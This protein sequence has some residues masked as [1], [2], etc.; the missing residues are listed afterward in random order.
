MKLIRLLLR[1]SRPAFFAALI[2]SVISGL[3]STF[4]I[5][6]ISRALQSANLLTPAFF[7]RFLTLILLVIGTDLFSKLVLN[8]LTEAAYRDMQISLAR[9]ILAAPIERLEAAGAPRLMVALTQ[10]VG[11]VT[12]FLQ[13][14]PTVSFHVAVAV[15]A[16]A[17]LFWVSFSTAMLMSVVMAAGVAGY[18]VLNGRARTHM[19]QARKI[20]DRIFHHYEG[21][22]LGAKELKLHGRRRLRFFERL[23]VPETQT[24]MD[25]RLTGRNQHEIANTWTNVMYFAFVLILFILVGIQGRVDPAILTSFTLVTLYLRSSIAHI[26]N[27]VPSYTY[28]TVALDAIEALQ[29]PPV[30]PAEVAGPATAAAP[31]STLAPDPTLDGSPPWE[32]VSLRDVTFAY[33]DEE[34]QRTFTLGPLNLTFHPGELVFLIGGNGSGKTTLIKLLT[35]LYTPDE[36]EILWDGATVTAETVEPY[37]QNFTAIFSDFYLFEDLLGFESPAHEEQARFY[38]ERLRLS[39]KVTISDGHLSTTKL[40]QGQRK[41]L[42]LLT[43]YLEDRPIYV[44]DE[45]AAGQDPQFTDIFYR[46]MLPELKE[47][48]KLVVVVSH[49]DHYFDVADRVIK[50]EYG[51]IE[52]DV[53]SVPAALEQSFAFHEPLPPAVRPV[54]VEP[55]APHTQ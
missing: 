24:Y 16:V 36:G 35:G 15:S 48:G 29:L 8:R 38:L 52:Y 47:R 49:D 44:F 9:Q 3:A 26:T 32:D 6:Q 54:P 27:T 45:W 43:A 34:Y 13:R 18:W 30:P 39:H 11:G 20:N 23:F 53:S 21:I 10:D 50:L 55:G 51:Q 31:A 5:A 12:T 33:T 14:L 40:S 46:V 4:L 41:R 28:A 42:A 2:A 17:Y 19:R 7:T 22:T 37:R 25:E 1:S